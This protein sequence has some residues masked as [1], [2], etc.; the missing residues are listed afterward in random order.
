MP[1]HVEEP[2]ALG[3]IL[4][5]E[6]LLALVD[7]DERRQRDWSLTFGYV[8]RSLLRHQRPGRA[9]LSCEPLCA[10]NRIAGHKLGMDSAGHHLPPALAELVGEPLTETLLSGDDASRRA[11]DGQ[12]QKLRRSP[13]SRPKSSA[14]EA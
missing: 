11:D 6:Q 12:W 10:H 3:G 14:Q 13:E 2:I 8:Q 1:H 7:G 4:G 5:S 9:H